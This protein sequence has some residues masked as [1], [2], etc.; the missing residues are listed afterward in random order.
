MPY[1]MNANLAD[2]LQTKKLISPDLKHQY[3][4]LW[5][6]SKAFGVDKFLVHLTA[7][8]AGEWCLQN[9]WLQFLATV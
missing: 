2:V 6:R 5:A 3:A 9:H 4:L 8:V 1:P 7:C